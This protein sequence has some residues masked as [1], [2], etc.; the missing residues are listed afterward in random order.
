MS[1]QAVT[2]PKQADPAASPLNGVVPPKEHRFKPGQSGNPAGRKPISE[3]VRKLMKDK[4][5]EI[6][7]QRIMDKVR[8]EGDVSAFKELCDRLEGKVP[9]KVE[10]RTENYYF[11]EEID[12]DWEDTAP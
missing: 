11:V 9:Q 6:L 12:R 5:A 2:T 3:A 8:E 1:D 4:E 7:V 10:A